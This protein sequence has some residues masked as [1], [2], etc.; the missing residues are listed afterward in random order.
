MKEQSFEEVDQF[1][2]DINLAKYKDLFLDHGVE[3]LETILEV[4]DKHL[5]EMG[6]PLGHK[7]KI[8]KHIKEMR[9][10]K[11]MTVPQSR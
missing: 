2:T 7:L 11:G 5:E 3:D 10:E 4:E 6:L 1:L 9:K 8:M